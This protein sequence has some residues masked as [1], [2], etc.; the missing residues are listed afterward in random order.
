MK[1]CQIQEQITPYLSKLFNE[2][3]GVDKS[4]IPDTPAIESY[5]FILLDVSNTE[6]LIEKMYVCMGKNN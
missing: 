6:S 1:D 4:N 2:V 5:R 3:L